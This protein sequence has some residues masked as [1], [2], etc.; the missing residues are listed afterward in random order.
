L[1]RREER[2]MLLTRKKLQRI[3]RDWRI[4][5][6][7]RELEK[8]LLEIY[9]HEF[10]TEEGLTLE[11]SEQDVVQGLRQSLSPYSLLVH[12]ADP[13]F[14]TASKGKEDRNDI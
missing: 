7:P 10:V 13:P 3:I 2:A 4:G 1:V 12:P 5:P 11:Y 8:E 6:I 14:L 9:G